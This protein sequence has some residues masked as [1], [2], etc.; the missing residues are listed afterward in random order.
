MVAF[1]K[2]LQIDN[3]FI[4]DYFLFLIMIISHTIT[5]EE[6]KE[7]KVFLD[8]LQQM[9]LSKE[10]YFITKGDNDIDKHLQVLSCKINNFVICKKK[11]WAVGWD[12]LDN[13]LTSSDILQFNNIFFNLFTIE[14]FK[15]FYTHYVFG[16]SLMSEVLNISFYYTL[17]RY[18]VLPYLLHISQLHNTNQK[19]VMVKYIANQLLHL[20][21]NK[22][23]FGIVEFHIGEELTSERI[24]NLSCPNY[25]IATLLRNNAPFVTFSASAKDGSKFDY[26]AH[27]GNSVML[28]KI[29]GYTQI[30]TETN[31]DELLNFKPITK[32]KLLNF[33][34]ITKDYLNSPQSKIFE[35]K[36]YTQIYTDEYNQVSKYIQIVNDVRHALANDITLTQQDISFAEQELHNV[37]K[38]D[39]Q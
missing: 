12:I 6:I 36:N 33:N 34:T 4:F 10:L 2:N 8:T 29:K 7:L 25:D 31:Q 32:D 21:I 19:Q 27:A 14:G 37:V 17:A 24:S 22:T 23:N 1:C 39:L 5:D 11:D 20:G 30:Y 26:S 15:Y 18:I 9:S 35:I 38:Q 3:F 13:M 16:T 28:F